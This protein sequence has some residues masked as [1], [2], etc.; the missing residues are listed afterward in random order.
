MDDHKVAV[1]GLGL[2]GSR[3]AARLIEHG[4]DVSGFDPEAE[5]S[6]AFERI[7]G[8]AGGS[9]FE[10]AE[11]CRAVIL[12]L[13]D[14]T[15]SREVCL[16]RGGLAACQGLEIVYDTTT[17]RPEDAV[18]IGAELAEVGIDY[19]DATLS[20]NSALAET[21]GLVVMVGGSD[22]AYRA[23]VPIF[24]VIGRSHHHVGPVGAG[25][26]MKLLVNQVLTIHRVALA[27]ALTTAE[28]AGMELES[29]LGV[30]RDSLAYSRAMDVWGERMVEGDHTAPA[31][32]LRQ[33]HKDT[34]LII[35]HSRQLG[36]PTGLIE[37]VESVQAGAKAQGLQ[38][39]DNSVVI[40]VLRRRVGR[41][42]VP[43]A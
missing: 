4:F 24:E 2:M 10:A 43:D 8:Q 3:L 25:S 18:S 21:G 12:S 38:D 19:C 32:R 9:P 35:E 14:S 20:G 5:R 23:G 31:S 16:G 27:E 39:L 29:V 30:L 41:G 36:A 6:A 42:R 22:A 7:G 1:I 37:V 33:G 13:P 15:V 34:Q 11:G 17:G 40:E 26:R 28:L